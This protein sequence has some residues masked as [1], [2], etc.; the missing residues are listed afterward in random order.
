MAMLSEN[1]IIE[2]IERIEHEMSGFIAAS[3]VD[4]DSGMTLGVKVK[5]PSFDVTTASAFNSELVKQ[6]LKILGAIG[7]DGGLDEILVTIDDQI[8]CIR[9]LSPSTFIYLAADR[10]ATNHAIV[11][12]VLTRHLRDF[13]A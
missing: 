9:L 5:D 1:Q 12:S 6:K 11:R 7:L 4:L 10:Q 13:E 3:L 8:H 2:S